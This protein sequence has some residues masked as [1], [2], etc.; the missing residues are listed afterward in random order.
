[1]TGT[2]WLAC[3]DVVNQ[4]GDGPAPVSDARALAHEEL[5]QRPASKPAF[6]ATLIVL[7][8]MMNT[9]Y[10]AGALQDTLMPRHRTPSWLLTFH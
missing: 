6:Q 7:M 4:P 3:L 9:E 2:E 5:L 8:R 10:L 1:M